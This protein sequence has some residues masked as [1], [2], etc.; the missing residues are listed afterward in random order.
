MALGFVAA[1]WLTSGDLTEARAKLA[2]CHRWEEQWQA[3][4]LHRTTDS[5]VLSAR[6]TARQAELGQLDQRLER[7]KTLIS[8][9]EDRR[10]EVLRWE[11]RLPRFQTAGGAWYQLAT[12][13]PV[14]DGTM[15]MEFVCV[16]RSPP[17]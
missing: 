9:L 15:T 2:D 17:P 13:P 12:W 6:I 8:R 16:R 10:L 1:L 7:L 3:S 14:V 5:L 11:G 4:L